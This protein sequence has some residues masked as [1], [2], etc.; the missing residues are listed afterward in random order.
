MSRERALLFGGAWGAG[1]FVAVVFVNDAVKPGY[2]PVRDF[3]S[4]A[5]IGAGG[6]VQ[7][8][9]FVV[10]GTLL[11]LSG[12]ALAR[13]VGR[14]TGVLVGVVGVGLIAAGVF[15]SDPVPQDES[16][17]HGVVHNVVSVMVFAALT[18]AC[19]TAARWRPTAGW[20]WYCRVTGV[21]VPVLFVTAGAVTNTSGFWQ[22][23]TIVVGWA[24]LVVLNLRAAA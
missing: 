13:V 17:W 23:V 10:A 22:R 3:V 18:G 16:A 9:N 14:W 20:R 7:I 11:A 8:A 4:E 24:W 19:F 5:A 6:W 2:E 1:L 21:A 15:V 12:V